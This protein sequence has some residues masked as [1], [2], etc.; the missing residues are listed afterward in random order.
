MPQKKSNGNPRANERGQVHSSKKNKITGTATALRGSWMQKS[1]SGSATLCQSVETEVTAP[2]YTSTHTNTHK[3]THKHTNQHTH[4]QTHKH[5]DAR[6][7]KH[8]H[9][10]TYK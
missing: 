6:M 10:N 7:H 3:C 5:T 1:E 8:T 4:I 9:A 2:T